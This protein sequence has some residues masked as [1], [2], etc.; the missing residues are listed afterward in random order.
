MPLAL[1]LSSYVASSRVGGVPQALSLSP[2]K[3]DPV[4]I[5]T[6]VLG[7]RP[8][9]DTPPGGG[10]LSPEF[11]ASVA[12][13]AAANGVLGLADVLICGYF[14]SP[15]QVLTAAALID[16][17]RMADRAGAYRPKLHV[18]VDP[19]MGDEPEGLY[20]PEAVADAI[21][22]ELLPRADVVTPNL[23][24]LRRLTGAPAS[25]LAEI[26]AAASTLP[27]PALVTSVPAG[28]GEIGG[29]YV[30]PGGPLL[31]AHRRRERIPHGTGDV[32]TAF[33]AAGLIQGDAPAD[34][35]VY[36]LQ[37][38]AELVQAAVD[39]SAPELPVVAAAPRMA[40]PTAPIRLQPLPSA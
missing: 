27:C 20:V 18:V 11:F 29:V 30:G 6:V 19:I 17:A 36:A 1:I 7:R 15:E 22:A 4:L 12:E 35:A 5:P 26:V 24:E 33:V 23:W 3:I 31:I 14:A 2:L 16:R 21:A 25:D 9:A 10:A 40:R 28:E 39:W 32:V 13:G 8:G 38:V 34:A 37:C